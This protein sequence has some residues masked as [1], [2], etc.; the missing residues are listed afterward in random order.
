M[1]LGRLRGHRVQ[2][3]HFAGADDAVAK[4]ALTLM[5]PETDEL[6][7]RGVRILVRLPNRDEQLVSFLASE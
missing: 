3:F 7:W 4:Y 1:L 6:Y 5:H 2:R